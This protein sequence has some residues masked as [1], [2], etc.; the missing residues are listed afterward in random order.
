M[1]LDTQP[2][3]LPGDGD[4]ALDEFRVRAAAE[5]NGLLRRLIDG[6]E[7]VNLNA[8]DGSSLTTTMWAVDTARGK[9]SFAA[10]LGD[11]RLQGLL[12][13]DRATV[14]AYLE[15]V[16]LQFDVK[17]LMLVHGTAASALQAE[18]PTQLYRFQRRRSFRVRPLARTS[19]VA[20][21]R[22]PMLPEMTLELRVLDVSIGGCALFLANDVPPL[23]PGVLINQVRIE[24]DGDTRFDASLRLQHV[25]MFN[26][27]LGGVRLGCEFIA[28]SGSAE[29][30]LQRFIDNTQ[31]RRRFLSLD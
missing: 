16:K 14:V 25:S 13:A 17:S 18:L 22:H 12:D 3:D 11:P 7:P 2:M 5:V 27:D 10:D 20:R 24:I 1:F 21:L 26:A 6:S 4:A 19:A 23:Q 31:K 9:L 15:N 29:R 30:A 28:L 8:P